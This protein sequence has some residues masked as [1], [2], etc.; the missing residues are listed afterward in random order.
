[1]ATDSAGDGYLRASVRCLP[2]PA[3]RDD[4]RSATWSPIATWRAPATVLGVGVADGP[5]FGLGGA[6]PGC[7]HTPDVTILDMLM[8][9]MDRLEAPRR[10]HVAA[11]THMPIPILTAD[12]MSTSLLR[13]IVYT[14][15]EE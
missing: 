8:S 15:G 6:D 9:R 13:G 14:T 3:T 1:M 11:A 7:D 10:L 5:D 2:P 12:N 4:L